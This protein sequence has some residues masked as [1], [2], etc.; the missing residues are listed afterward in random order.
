MITLASSKGISSAGGPAMAENVPQDVSNESIRAA[1][2]EWVEDGIEIRDR[3]RDL[4]LRA[5]SSRQFD[6]QA[7][8]EVVRA[9]TEGIAVGAAKRGANVR[10]ALADAV[11]GLDE[12]LMKSAEAGRLALQELISRNRDFS[13]NEIKQAL[14]NLKKMEEDF[15]ATVHQVAQAA[16]PVVRT[17][18][19]DLLTHM[20]RAGTDTGMKVAS[21]MNEFAHRM[22]NAYVDT[23]I[24]GLE[25]T[26]ELSSRWSQMASG[27]LA[28]L[29]EA[30]RKDDKQS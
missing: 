10:A 24:A 27:L 12:A 6:P 17:Q 5:I 23:H 28:G 20:R 26:R 29:S 9:A 22:A 19:D 18:L 16:K 4:T 14:G 7:V 11:Q 30:L 25:A 8:R 21:T 2:S 1:A 13:E 15:L 3:V